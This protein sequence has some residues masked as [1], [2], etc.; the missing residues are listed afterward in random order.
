MNKKHFDFSQRILELC[1]IK[2]ISIYKLVDLSGVPKATL[3]RICH[4]KNTPN[5]YTL[6][7]ICNALDITLAQFFT[8]DENNHYSYDLQE[9][10]TY[11]Q[12]LSPEHQQIILSFVKTLKDIKKRTLN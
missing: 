9:L 8:I 10:I 12:L 3:T 6:E 5:F 7:K 11:F 4:Q 2:G 1:K